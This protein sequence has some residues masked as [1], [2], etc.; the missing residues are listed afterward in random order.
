MSSYLANKIVAHISWDFNRG[1]LEEVWTITQHPKFFIFSGSKISCEYRPGQ[2]TVLRAEID[3][4][5]EIRDWM[6]VY[7]ARD[8][9]PRFGV[10]RGDVLPL[11]VKLPVRWCFGRLGW[12]GWRLSGIVGRWW[13]GSSEEAEE[14]KGVEEGRSAFEISSPVLDICNETGVARISIS[15][16]ELPL[17]RSRGRRTE[18]GEENRRVRFGENTVKYFH[19]DEMV[20]KVKREVNRKR[21]KFVRVVGKNSKRILYSK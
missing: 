21:K 7:V 18:R 10:R 16:T 8:V 19:Q 4:M 5:R 15:E 13:K 2:S 6:V 9:S 20:A 1:R 17:I 11:V 12:Y 3:E 14:I